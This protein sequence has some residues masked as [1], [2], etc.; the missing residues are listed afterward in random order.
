[1]DDL[2][3]EILMDH[4]K[5]PRNFE[6]TFNNLNYDCMEGQYPNCTESIKF[7]IKFNNS[8]IEDVKWH[9]TG[10]IILMSSS[11]VFSEYCINKNIHDLYKDIS[12]LY[13]FYTGKEN[14]LLLNDFEYF[15]NIKNYPRRLKSLTLPLHCIL[16]ILKRKV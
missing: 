10:S 4:G 7:F 15:S 1:M 9:G 2:Y 5:N 8:I 6:K 13:N 11:S 16:Q 3:Q 12:H 14:K